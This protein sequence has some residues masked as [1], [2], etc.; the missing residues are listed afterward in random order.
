MLPWGPKSQVPLPVSTPHPH[1]VLGVGGG[2]EQKG[3]EGTPATP[4]SPDPKATGPRSTWTA[5]TSHIPCA[6]LPAASALQEAQGPLLP[7]PPGRT[8]TTAPGGPL[9][10]SWQCSVSVL[11]GSWTS[12]CRQR[13]SIYFQPRILTSEYIPITLLKKSMRIISISQLIAWRAGRAVSSD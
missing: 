11:S 4:L 2:A 8:R 3:T 1:G 9:A 10:A 6:S 12:A 5:A 13:Q 7:G